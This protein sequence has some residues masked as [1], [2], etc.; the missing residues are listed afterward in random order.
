MKSMPQHGFTL[1]ELMVAVAIVGILAA[2][3]APAYTDYVVRGRIPD[4]TNALATK[5]VRNE[6]FF[7]DNR[8][9]VGAPG[10]TSDTTTSKHFDFNCS[11]ATAS[12]FVLRAVGKGG[13]TGFTYTLNEAGV[14]ATAAAP[15]DYG[16]N[17]TC[18]VIKK[19]GQ[20]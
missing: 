8:T 13:M 19:G 20:C 15:T 5:A 6:Q 14:R 7:Q 17:A 9:Y 12:A 11:S 4:A 2:I 18:W 3:A 10:C 16:T 1:I